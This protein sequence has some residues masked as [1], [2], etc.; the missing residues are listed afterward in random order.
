MEFLSAMD[1]PRWM[2]LAVSATLVGLTKAGFEGGSLLAVP[3]M[4]A[5]FGARSSSGLLL[6]VLMTAD[7]VAVWNYRREGSLTH[8]L[9]TL[10]WAVAG[11]VAGALTGKYI[12]DRLFRTLMAVFILSSAVLMAWRE[13]RGGRFVMTGRWWAAA[14]LGLLAG[15]SSMV[16]NAAGPVMGL[17]LLSSGLPKTRIVG[18]SVWFFF[19]ANLVK[20]PFHVFVWKSF[21]GGTLLA[22][23]AVA[24]FAIGATFLGVR[25]V[26]LIPE[27]PYRIFLI[28]ASVAGGLYLALR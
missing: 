4:A 17:Y 12:D 20:L 6:G 24:P 14:P 25:L 13:L 10:P 7:L 8:L 28:C 27:K 26:R 23:L 15:F 1:L 9:K 22:D 2:A 18:T 16:G 19:L 3:L 11:I 5:I 21:S